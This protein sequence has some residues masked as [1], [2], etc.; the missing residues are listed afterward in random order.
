LSPL[1]AQNTSPAPGVEATKLSDT[2]YQLTCSFGYPVN[3]LV[4]VGPDGVMLVDAGFAETATEIR[5]TA[6][7]LGG[8][9]IRFIV[10]THLHND[11]TGGNAELGGDATIIAHHNTARYLSG[12]FFSLPAVTPPGSPNLSVASEITLNF[13]GERIRVY[14]P[15]G[16]HTDGDLIVH[17][18]ESKVACLGDLLFSETFPF[19][20]VPRGGDADR[21]IQTLHE[22]ARGFPSDTVLVAGHGRRLSPAELAEYASMLEDTAVVVH[23][24]LKEGKTTQQIQEEN[25]LEAWAEYSG[26]TLVS[27]DSWVLWIANSV[28]KRAGGLVPS[29]CEPLTKILVSHGIEAAIKT[30]HELATNRRDD[31]NFGEAHLNVLGYQLLGRDMVAEAIAVLKLNAEAY[32]ESSNVYDSLAEAYMTNGDS[33]QA[34]TNYQRSL[35]LDPSNTNA[36]EKLKELRSR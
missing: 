14:S 28:Q 27:S 17:F 23:R 5:K 24:A 4:S 22:L 25:L 21:Q 26:D 9:P 3:A 32:P 2:L 29:I 30:Y 6:S 10:N 20:D 8:G 36:V 12:A 35:E 7:K 13:N 19:V 33:K 15:T 16:G 1:S 31:F 11:H 34:I 18:P